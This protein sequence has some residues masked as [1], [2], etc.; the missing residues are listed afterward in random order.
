MKRK[1]LA[2]MALAVSISAVPLTAY[3][4]ATVSDS[5]SV[6]TES[7]V[8]TE[9]ETAE[10]TQAP[11]QSAVP[12]ETPGGDS[13]PT[14]SPSVTPEPSVT[15]PAQDDENSESQD[16]QYTEGWNQ[17][18]GTDG[19]QHWI[20]Y[21]AENGG[22]QQGLLNLNEKTYLTDENGYLQTGAQQYTD[23]DGTVHNFYFSEEGEKPGTDSDYGVQVTGFAAD[24]KYYAPD[25]ATD[26]IVESDGAHYYAG[27]DGTIVKNGFVTVSDEDG[28]RICYF[29]QDGRQ[30]EDAGWI[31]VDSL[32]YYILDGQVC[33]DGNYASNQDE[34]AKWLVIEGD[35]FLIDAHD[36]HRLSGLQKNGNDLYYLDPEQDDKMFTSTNDTDGWKRVDGT[37]YFFRSWGGALNNGWN[38]LGID[39]YWFHEDGSMASDE[40][41]EDGGNLY[42]LRDWGG[43]LYDQWRQDPETT[44]WYYFRGWG[45]ALNCGWAKIGIDWYWFDSDCTMRRND[46]VE[47]GGN[48]Y[49]VRDW[50]GMLYDAWQ[51]RNGEWYYFRSWGAA[52][53]CGWAKIGNDWYWFDTDCT[54]ARD[55]WLQ[56]GSD[57][58]Y[59][60]DWGGRLHDQWYKVDNDWYYFGSDGKMLHDQWLKDGNDWYYLRGW[61]GMMHDQWYTE[62]GKTYYFRSWGGRLYGG[63]FVIDGKS[64]TFDANGCR[65][66]AGWVYVDGYRRYRNADGTLSNDVSAIFNPSSKFITVDRIRGITTIY[67]YNSETGKYDTPIKSMW[68]S[69]GNPITLSAAGTYHIGW[70]LPSKKMVGEGNS[71]VCWASYV[72]QIYGAVYFHGVAS[73]SPDLN[74]VAKSDFEALGRPMS[75][76]CIR[77]AACD[78]KWI[79]ENT[80]TGTTVQIGDNL[81]CPMSNPVRYQWTGG[82]YGPD[83]TYS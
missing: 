48:L 31:T 13:T 60:R 5:S 61:G 53:N 71:Y 54:M 67:G 22:V 55:Q 45:A 46:W 32:S 26:Q 80:S 42:Y 33:V 72:S 66:D 44:E 2:A 68:C 52:L 62:N 3:A 73:G 58:Y 30:V 76:G 36:G 12:T 20:Y 35:W 4:S 59:L 7:Q 41:L 63:T 19:A 78:A 24:G 40:W 18:T 43:M 34:N 15:P 56:Q 9:S 69:V 77:L 81:G 8:N 74:S 28:D 16:S 27:E 17:V 6:N 51:L 65:V 64:Y 50:G 37:W 47:E 57:W 23:E 11:E 10:V 25:L 83:P 1:F 79:Y 29:D 39:Y 21:D 38:K 70:Q 49:Y 14:P 82:A 75:H